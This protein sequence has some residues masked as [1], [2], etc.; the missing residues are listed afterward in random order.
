MFIQKL[1]KTLP[2]LGY[3]LCFPQPGFFH[4][5]FTPI[6]DFTAQ[7]SYFTSEHP[8]NLALLIQ[9]AYLILVSMWLP[10]TALGQPAV[11]SNLLFQLLNSA[12][13]DSAGTLLPLSV[14]KILYC[15]AAYV[16][17]CTSLLFTGL[18]LLSSI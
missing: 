4:L 9:T 16:H 11:N 12:Y 6:L 17:Q 10:G 14:A 1:F 15:L 5:I 8:P 7:T 2:Q 18:A 13:T 3:F